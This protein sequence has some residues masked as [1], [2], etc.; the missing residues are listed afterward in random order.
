MLDFK[1]SIVA[2]DFSIHRAIECIEKSLAK[3]ALVV[4]GNGRLCGT[5]TDGDIRRGILK[6]V[7]LDSPIS[8]VMNPSPRTALQTEDRAAL[9]AMMR[10]ELCKHLPLVD[11]DGRLV[12]IVTLGELLQLQ[13]RS[14]WV[15]LMA[16]GEGR[17]LRPLTETVPKPLLSVGA[18]PILETVLDGFISAGFT[19]FFISVNYLAERVES[20]FGDGSSRGV[21]IFY[22]REK[23]QLGTAGALSL[24]PSRP[25]EP[26]FV[27]NSDI[28][29]NI[30]YGHLLEFHREHDAVGTMCVREHAFNIPY[31]VVEVDAHRLRGIEEKPTIRQF[32]N[33]GIYVFAPEAVDYVAA[34]QPIDMPDLFKKMMSAGK[35][36]VVFPVRE[37]W[38]DIGQLDDYTRANL[39]FDKNFL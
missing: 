18:K 21:E 24:L 30:D 4:D 2:P 39:D 16:G 7:P 34:G 33:A 17:R 36:C 14:N 8:G 20:Y 15:V 28:L 11:K 5:V 23:I 29:T 10:R 26:F 27:M 32:L 6:G 3:I 19:R 13:A 22:L 9:L 31:G 37:Y 1:D 25:T 38:T 12:G 35:E